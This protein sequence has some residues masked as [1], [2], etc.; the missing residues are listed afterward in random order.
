MLTTYDMVTI[1]LEEFKGGD[2]DTWDWVVLDE[3]STATW[4]TSAQA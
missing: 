2:N 3:V 1:H 4:M